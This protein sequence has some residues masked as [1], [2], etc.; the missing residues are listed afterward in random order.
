MV[1]LRLKKNIEN[2]EYRISPGVVV[3]LMII[4]AFLI[5]TFIICLPDL[6]LILRNFIAKFLPISSLPI[7]QS[8]TLTIG[9]YIIVII[10]ICDCVITV[11]LTVVA[12]HLSK[13]VGNIQIEAQRAQNI[14][15][16]ARVADFIDDNLEAIYKSKQLNTIPHNLD[17]KPIYST[18]VVNLCTSHCIDKA[19]RKMLENCL[20]CF[21]KINESHNDIAKIIMDDIIKEHIDMTG[22]GKRKQTM[23]KLLEK[24]NKIRWEGVED[25]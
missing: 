19:E 11:A 9:D 7:M 8:D 1:N 3:F 10:S 5:C 24:L 14:L 13:A 4:I 25:E 12:Y 18:D 20:K 21:Q 22:V 23:R 16:A 6:I 15:S 17:V 2:R